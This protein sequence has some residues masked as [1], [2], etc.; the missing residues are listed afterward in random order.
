[1]LALGAQTGP[2]FLTYR[3]SAEVDRDRRRRS[4]A[5]EPIIDFT[6]P[7]EVRH[8]LWRVGGHDRDALVAAFARIPA[9][10]IADGHHRAASAARA[11]TEMRDKQIAGTSL[12]DGAG[13]GTML[14]VAFP[15]DQVQILAYNRTVK[16]LGGLSPDA[17]L[18]AVREQF[19]GDGRS[20]H[21][22]Q[23][24]RHRDVLSR[25]VAD[26]AAKA[27]RRIRRIRSARSTSACCRSAC[28][29]R[30]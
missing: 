29:R 16:D 7:D 26:A 5:G 15:H 3:A 18:A 24:R 11:R 9:L 12:G 14:A 6:A 2:V 25:R 17:F 27:S 28:S 10:Y 1:M 19:D 21:A 13:A 22:R 23:A 4:T 8:T 30:S 20:G